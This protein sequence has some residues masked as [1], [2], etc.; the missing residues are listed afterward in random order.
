MISISEHERARM[1]RLHQI[2]LKL[3]AMHRASN[4][5]LKATSARISLLDLMR[6]Y[7]GLEMADEV[8]TLD[9]MVR[10]LDRQSE[11]LENIIVMNMK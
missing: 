2:D 5:S 9:L 1:K 7:Q 4:A 3:S 10:E 6:A 8:E 11:A